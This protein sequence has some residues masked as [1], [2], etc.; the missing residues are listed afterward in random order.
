MIVI[1]FNSKVPCDK[2]QGSTQSENGKSVQNTV[3][4][5]VEFALGLN[6]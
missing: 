5:F 6:I 1:L 4:G 3:S 2:N